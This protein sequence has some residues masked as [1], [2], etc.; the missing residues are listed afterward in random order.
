MKKSKVCLNPDAWSVIRS[1]DSQTVLTGNSRRSDDSQT[2]LQGIAE[3][4]TIVRP[5]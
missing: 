2:V 1:D 4:Q 5:L 3:G